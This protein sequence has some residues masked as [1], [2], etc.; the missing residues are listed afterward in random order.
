MYFTLSAFLGSLVYGS[1]AACLSQY[2]IAISDSG[3]AEKVVGVVLPVNAFVVVVFQYL[4]GKRIRPDKTVSDSSSPTGTTFQPR[5]ERTT[6][7]A[8]SSVDSGKE[9]SPLPIRH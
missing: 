8:S 4:V 3:L 7:K 6:D 5:M 9:S 1:F 2:A